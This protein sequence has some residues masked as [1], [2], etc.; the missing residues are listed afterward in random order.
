MAHIERQSKR[1][2]FKD[3]METGFIEVFPTK[4]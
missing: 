3:V 2:I 4:G 1:T